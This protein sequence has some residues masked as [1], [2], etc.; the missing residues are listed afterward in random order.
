VA[1][2]NGKGPREE[3]LRGGIL[4]ALRSQDILAVAEARFGLEGWTPNLGGFDFAIIATDGN[5]AVGETK[6]TDHGLSEAIWDILKLASA[7][8]LPRINAAFAVYA[9]PPRQWDT[10]LGQLLSGEHAVQLAYLLE[11]HESD[12]RWNLAGSPNV[13]PHRLPPG[14]VVGEL[15]RRTTTAGSR[16]WEVRTL[17]VGPT[18]GDPVHLT[19]GWPNRAS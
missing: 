1:L 13:R 4:A 9:A 3:D 12:W 14:V 11:V 19:D 7:I 16:D 17:S 8:R 18:I 5:V 6:W 10:E 2:R 15:D